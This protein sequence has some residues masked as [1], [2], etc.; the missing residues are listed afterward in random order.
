MTSE[1]HDLGHS[2]YTGPRTPPSRRFWVVA[3]NVLGVAWKSRWGVKLPFVIAAGTTLAAA[4]VMYFLRL[5]LTE[6]VRARGAPIPQAEAIVFMAGAFYEFSAF[7]LALVVGCALVANDLRMGAFQFYFARALRPRDYVAGKLLGLALVVGI[8]MLLGPLVL[9]VMRLVYAET[10]AHALELAPVVPRA[11]AHGLLGTLAYTLPVAGLS[12]LAGKRQ[13]AQAFYIVY[14]MLF[15]SA[16]FVISQELRLPFLRVIS[17]PNDLSVL[18]EAIFGLPH[19]PFDPP[20]W[21]S[22]LS[23]ATFSAAGAFVVWWRVRGAE[24]A[25]LGNG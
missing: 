24:T 13:V 2:A 8:P 3:R 7:I 21:A 1:I 5:R 23:L 17:L 20:V 19:N 4:A 6:T 9:A 16:S 14:Y 22:A 25:G 18:G 12:A 10:P 15:V 11:I